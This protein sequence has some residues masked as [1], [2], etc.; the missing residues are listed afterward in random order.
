[1]RFPYGHEQK[2]PYDLTIMPDLAERWEYL[3]DKTVVFYLRKGVKFHNKPPVNGRELKAQ[4]VKYSLERFT[5]K[6]GFRARFDDVDRVEVVDDYTVKIITKHPFAPLLAQLASPSHNMI[7]PKEAEDQYGDFNK[8]EA[9]IGTGSFILER[10][11]RGVKL[12]F[13]RNPDFYMKGLPYV[14]GIE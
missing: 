7:L 4:D 10:Y 12:I 6:S 3:D 13:K 14:D 9:A 2:S 8:A 1:V 5:A 11:E